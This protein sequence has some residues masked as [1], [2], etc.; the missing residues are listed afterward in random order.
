MTLESV[1]GT[2]QPVL[3]N[4]G[5][6]SCSRKQRGPLMGLKPTTSTLRVRRATHGATRSD[7]EFRSRY[8][9][10]AFTPRCLSRLKM[11][12]E[13]RKKF[14]WAF[15]KKGTGLIS[16]PL[17]GCH[18][19]LWHQI[20]TF[21]HQLNQLMPRCDRHGNRRRIWKPQNNISLSLQKQS[22]PKQLM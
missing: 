11:Y 16:L 15:N 17:H 13:S 9:T 19:M 8:D 2:M 10:F 4:K 20:N 14:P 21:N 22:M 1:P 18:F 5:K 6:V 7:I 3:S 12:K